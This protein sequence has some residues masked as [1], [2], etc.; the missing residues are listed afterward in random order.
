MK[1][2][3][4]LTVYEAENEIREYLTDLYVTKPFAPK[5]KSNT[6]TTEEM[7]IYSDSVLEY[8]KALEDYKFKNDFYKAESSRLYILLEDKI[9]EDSGFNNIPEQYRNKVYSY[10]YSQGHSSGYGDVFNYLCDLVEI[11]E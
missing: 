9:K 4:D 5:L 8:E 10:A 2:I 7:E 6:P 3:D 11:F 1:N